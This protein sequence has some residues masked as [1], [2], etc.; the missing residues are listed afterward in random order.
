M[1]ETQP[2]FE[3]SLVYFCIQKLDNVQVVPFIDTRRLSKTSITTLAD[4]FE[5]LRQCYQPNMCEL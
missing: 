5:S 1:I 4:V 2:A 3:T